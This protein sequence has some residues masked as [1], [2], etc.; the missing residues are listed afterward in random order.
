MPEH[1]YTS[2]QELDQ[3]DFHPAVTL[4]VPLAAVLLQSVLPKVLAWTMYFDLP[5]VVV[6]Y[7]AVARRSQIAGT[8]TGT[9]IGLFQ[10]GLTNHPFGIEGIAKG[11]VGY[12]AASIGFAVDLD[13]SLNRVALNFVFSA[14]QTG[15]LY[16]ISR[17]L[18]GDSTVLLRPVHGLIGAACNAALSVPVFYLLDRFRMRD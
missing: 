5:L 8:V 14:I 13:N 12:A 7:F 9:I 10:D 18:L 17:W 4:L 16:L 15:L 6:I 3:Y 1:S 2:R 11:I